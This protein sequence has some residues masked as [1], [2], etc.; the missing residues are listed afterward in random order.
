MKTLW[1]SPSRGAAVIVLLTVVA[2]I[3]AMRGG[4]IWDDHSL[5]VDSPPIKQSDGLYRFWCTT[6]PPDYWPLTYTTWWLEWRLWGKN[7]LGYHVVNVI[8]H[9]LS[10]MLWWRVLVRLKVPGAWLASAVFAV[11]PV[12][13]ESV[14]WI[15]E[16]KNT[17]AMPFH[18]LTLL[19]YLRFEDSGQR[20]WYWLALG[21][22]V[23]GAAKQ[24]IGGDA[25]VCAAGSCVVATRANRTARMY[26]A[27]FRSLR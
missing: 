16:R 21:T 10:A 17:L 19:C 8:L 15:A 24:G 20:R 9:V 27:V 7:P 18:M 11:H 13:V 3:P 2:Y 14:A 1:R 4:F 6:Q 5:V 23:S 22:F 25:A 12:N 26:C